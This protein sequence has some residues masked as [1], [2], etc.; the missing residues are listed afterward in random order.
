MLSMCTGPAKRAKWAEQ[1][2]ENQTLKLLLEVANVL[3]ACPQEAGNDVE[4]YL[5]RY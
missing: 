1:P 4:S 5:S 3:G 2:P